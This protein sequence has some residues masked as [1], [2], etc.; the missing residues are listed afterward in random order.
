MRLQ[1]LG[2]KKFRGE[3]EAGGRRKWGRGGDSGGEE[4]GQTEGGEGCE[5]ASVIAMGTVHTQERPA[6]H[7]HHL[8]RKREGRADDTGLH[9]LGLVHGFDCIPV[10]L[11][12]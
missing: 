11:P 9:G 6:S 4:H 7:S 8:H 3:S 10:P 12:L 5:V 2:G 1:P